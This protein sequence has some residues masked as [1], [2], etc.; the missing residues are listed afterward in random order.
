VCRGADEFRK[1]FENEVVEG[2]HVVKAILDRA[3]REQADL[4]AIV[5]YERMGL[6]GFVAGSVARAVLRGGEFSV[7]LVRPTAED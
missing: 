6:S 1:P 3:R 4:I 2:E 7:M 5:T